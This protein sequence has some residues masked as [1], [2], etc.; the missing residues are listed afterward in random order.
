LKS[1]WN[2]FLFLILVFIW[3]TGW[4]VLKIGVTYVDPL[5]FTS[6]RF[7]VAALALTPLL[8][9]YRKRIPGDWRSMFGLFLLGIFFA[10]GMILTLTGLASEKVGVSAILTYTQPLFVVC[11]A[12]PFLKEKASANRLAGISIGFFGVAILSV[13]DFSMISFTYSTFLLIVGAFFWAVTVVFYK[14]FLSHIDPIVTNVFQFG[15]GSALLAILILGSG[16][17]YFHPSTTYL[18][19]I[20]YTSL[21]AFGLAGIIWIYLLR[22]EEATILSTSSLIIPVIAFFF[23]WLFFEEIIELK[24]LIGSLLILLGVYLVNKKINGLNNRI[25]YKPN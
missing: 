22:E 3:G 12:A 23:G 18:V 17:F 1:L 9:F 16:N 19:V 11:M 5:N 15:W 21:V 7:I 6:H 2:W 24:S 4:L 14:K 13:K 8:I 10:L 20:L 25:R